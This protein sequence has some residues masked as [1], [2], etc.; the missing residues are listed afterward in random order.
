[1]RWRG[2]CGEIAYRCGANLT[3]TAPFCEHR[4]FARFAR[5]VLLLHSMCVNVFVSAAVTI[6]FDIHKADPPAAPGDAVDTHRVNQ[7]MRTNS[8]W[9][10]GAI[11]TSTMMSVCSH[12]IAMKLIVHLLFLCIII[13]CYGLLYLCLHVHRSLG[14]ACECQG[15]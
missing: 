9:I 13:R 11:S 1:V 14:A 4:H 15:K 6:G 8:Y 3:L 10:A 12:I 2:T 5:Y 7:F